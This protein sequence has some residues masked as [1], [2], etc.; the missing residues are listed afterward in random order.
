[1]D[2][3]SIVFAG[4]VSQE[5]WHL[6][7]ARGRR[8]PRLSKKEGKRNSRY[9]LPV[10]ENVRKKEKKEGVRKRRKE[11]NS[12]RQATE[13]SI[14]SRLHAPPHLFA[15]KCRC[16]RMGSCISLVCWLSLLRIIKRS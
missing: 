3:G 14:R 12:R 8:C 5:G 1:M 6:S 7:E 15:L 4:R 11:V 16:W 10:G 9:F 2:S 13:V